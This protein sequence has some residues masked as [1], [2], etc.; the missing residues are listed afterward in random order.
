MNSTTEIEAIER[1]QVQRAEVEGA[2]LHL[3]EITQEEG[4]LF[5][6]VINTGFV[7]GG[8][9]ATFEHFSD[10]DPLKVLHAI[11]AYLGSDSWTWDQQKAARLRP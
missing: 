11:D 7:P 1:W 5:S 8:R 10:K 2:R 3:S 4:G 9:F 6:T